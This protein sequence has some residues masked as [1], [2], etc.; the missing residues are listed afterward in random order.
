[1]RLEYKMITKIHY[2]GN[3]WVWREQRILDRKAQTEVPKREINV[4]KK[5]SLGHTSPYKNHHHKDT[6]V[7]NI[8]ITDEII[9]A[10]QYEKRHHIKSKG[11]MATNEQGGSMLNNRS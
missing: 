8:C 4:R 6:Y 2:K 5:W 11:G 10:T 7:S 1:M 9:M 3:N